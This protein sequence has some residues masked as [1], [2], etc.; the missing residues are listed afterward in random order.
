MF[1]DSARITIKAGD[2]GRGCIAFRREKYVPRGGPSGG[3]GGNGGSIYFESSDQLNTL[4]QFR[5]RR[6]FKAGRGEHGLGSDCHG[7]RG[8]DLVI[9]VPVGSILYLEGHRNPLHEFLKSGER[10]LIARGGR[11][12]RGNA[13]FATSTMQAPRIAEDGS[14]GEELQLSIELKLLADVGLVGFPN[15][16]KSTLL[17]VISA[18][19]PKIADYPFTTLTPHLGVVR[20]D[21]EREF[22]A[23][24]IPGLVEGAHDGRGLGD[25]FLKHIERTRLLLHLVD[26]SDS[27]TESPVDRFSAIC[28]ELELFSPELAVKP[29]IV[30]ASKTDAAVTGDQLKK[31]QNYCKRRKLDCVGIAAVTGK[32]LKELLELTARRLGKASAEHNER[33]E[34]KSEIPPETDSSPAGHKRSMRRRV[35]E[36]RGPVVKKITRSGNS[37]PRIQDAKTHK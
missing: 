28:H 1:I 21:E 34:K 4:L 18:A 25:L 37:R 31:L 26:V 11:G 7:R 2:G 24:D 36:A 8:D 22:V 23:A 16:G 5:F 27:S 17:S 6:H 14:P 35:S 13:R 33:A 30:V 15:A 12:G 9:T 3:D 29:Q 19:R 10:V 20:L 32:G